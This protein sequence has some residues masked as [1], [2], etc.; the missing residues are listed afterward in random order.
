MGSMRRCR[1]VHLRRSASE[2]G[3]PE[4]LFLENRG[5]RRWRRPVFLSD[6]RLWP[7]F[8]SVFRVTGNAHRPGKRSTTESRNEQ[9]E[10]IGAAFVPA[11]RGEALSWRKPRLLPIP[12]CLFPRRPESGLRRLRIGDPKHGEYGLKNA[13]MAR[14]GPT[15]RTKDHGRNLG[16]GQAFLFWWGAKHPIRRKRGEGENHGILSCEQ[17][18]CSCHP[19]FPA[20][21]PPR[22]GFDERAGDHPCWA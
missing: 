13:K 18:S 3:Q 2:R 17:F 7:A 20:P 12:P 22:A 15:G 14:H 11:A 1:L 6:I 8:W 10:I 9:P 4:G 21:L 16:A 5:P 19:T